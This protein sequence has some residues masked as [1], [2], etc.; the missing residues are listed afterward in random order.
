MQNLVI[1]PISIFGP[2]EK[3][4]LLSRM[5]GFIEVHENFQKRS[6]RN[7][8]LILGTNG[9]LRLSIPLEKGKTNKPIKEVKISYAE[10]WIKDYLE[11]I[12][13]AYGNSP[14]FEFYFD[15][16]EQIILA[17]PLYLFDLFENSFQFITKYIV[18]NQWHYTDKYQKLYN[19]A[20]DL[21]TNNPSLYVNTLVYD[22]VFGDKYN[23]T[24]ALSILDLLFNL[25]PES[26]RVISKSVILD[27]K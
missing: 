19:D 15:Q 4:V 9:I 3:Y 23:F 13:S 27:N 11:G 8:T 26:Q 17:K 18:I 24:K 20:I 12:R 14:Y 2:I 5:N 21:R 25:G 10:N 16:I 6:F 1:S 22:Q 7:R